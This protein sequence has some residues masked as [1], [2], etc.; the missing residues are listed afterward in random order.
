MKKN[1]VTFLVSFLFF[2][3][4]LHSCLPSVE[5]ALT[6]ES[7]K[8]LRPAAVAKYHLTQQS[9]NQE[10]DNEQKEFKEWRLDPRIEIQKL[11]QETLTSLK[12]PSQEKDVL[13]ILRQSWAA[14][15]LIHPSISFEQRIEDNFKSVSNI[16]TDPKQAHCY[17]GFKS[18]REM[19]VQEVL[20]R[21]KALIDTKALLE[22]EI[23]DTDAL[24]L[25]DFFKIIRQIYYMASEPLNLELFKSYCEGPEALFETLQLYNTALKELSIEQDLLQ[26]ILEALCSK[27]EGYALPVEQEAIKILSEKQQLYLISEKGPNIFSKQ[28][29]KPVKIF[30]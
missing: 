12:S 21:Y 18:H 26:K 6:A 15:Q 22:K 30:F 2:P 17:L 3:L 8:L 16:M 13:E 14:A 28:L 7:L 5:N 11:I 9:E 1:V 10:L 20:T 29:F 4:F 23:T 19:T 25:S 27:K 24:L